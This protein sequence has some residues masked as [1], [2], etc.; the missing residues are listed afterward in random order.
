MREKRA[1]ACILAAVMF[2]LCSFRPGCRIIANGRVLPGIHDLTVAQRCASAARQAAEEI[3]RSEEEVPFTLIPVLCLQREETD[4]TALYH[5]LLEA[6][7]GVEKLYTVSVDGVPVGKLNS[8]WAATRIAHE[9]PHRAVEVSVTYSYP[10]AAD[11]MTHVRTAM[12]QQEV[13][14]AEP[15]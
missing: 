8:L 13:G 9:F 11:T 2:M 12:R 10:E 14:T 15:F 7:E 3:T 5:T 1:F 6:Y 4:E